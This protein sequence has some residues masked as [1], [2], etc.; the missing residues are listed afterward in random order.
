MPIKIGNII[1]YDLLELSNKLDI[2]VTALRTYI[3]E[4][5]LLAVKVGNKW[6][7][8]EEG[9]AKFFLGDT[10]ESRFLANPAYGVNVEHHKK[11]KST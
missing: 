8:S 9:L 1:V 11:R 2:N 4:G 5:K 6:Q 3:K 7:V 10:G